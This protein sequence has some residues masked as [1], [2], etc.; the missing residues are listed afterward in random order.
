[1]EASDAELVLAIA[2]PGA[3]AREAEAELCRRFAPRVYLYG[4]RHLRDE[5]RARD[6]VQSVLLA[7]LQAAR[8]G[9]VEDPARVDRF[10][11][12]TCRNV[13]ARLRA[14]DA[15]NVGPAPLEALP[16][17]M[18]EI[19]HAGMDM[20]RAALVRCV[21][22]LDQRARAVVTLTFLEEQPAEQIAAR[23]AITTG[24]V[25]V[26]RHRAVAALR[27]CLDARENQPQAV[28]A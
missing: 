27:R 10:M 4:R 6:L 24:N 25:R 26:V 14:V 28:H 9:R 21:D 2:R 22:E 18:P 19:G 23:L 20:D 15:R 11:L 8:A 1:M 7:V 5:D 3:G 12:G 17:P 13:A 16:D